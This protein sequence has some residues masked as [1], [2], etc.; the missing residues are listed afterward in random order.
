MPRESFPSDS[1]A[2]LRRE[3]ESVDR[4]IVLLIAARMDAARRALQL[5]VANGRQ[6]TDEAQE[7]Q[8]LERSRLWAR[9]LGLS[10]LLVQ[11]LFRTLIEEGKARFRSNAGPAESGLVTVLLAAADGTEVGLRSVPRSQLDAVPAPR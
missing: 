7:R 3:I 1:L 11:D 8:V 6:V 2:D 5:R 9:E 4:S 10:E